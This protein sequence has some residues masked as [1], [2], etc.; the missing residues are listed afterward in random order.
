MKTELVVLLDRSGSMQSIKTDMEGGFNSF[1][2]EQKKVPGACDVTLVQFDDIGRDVAWNCTDIH[3]VGKLDLRPRGYTPLYDAIC[4]TIDE[5]GV[6][7]KETKKETRPDKVLFVII[8]DGHEN[9]SKKFRMED[10]RKRVTHQKDV[11]KWEFV[12]LGA[13]IDSYA[14]GNQMGLSIGTMSNYDPNSASVQAMYANLSSS[15]AKY[16]STPTAAFVLTPEQQ[17]EMEQK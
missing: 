13:N 16:R 15:T 6:R 4:E 3:S 12:F 5:V 14:L 17:A 11:Y 8:T 10:V 7:L 2:E 1:V 9:A